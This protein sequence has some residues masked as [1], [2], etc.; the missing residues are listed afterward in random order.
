MRS[1]GRMVDS[2]SFGCFL[3]VVGFIRGRFGVVAFI[4]VRLV[5]VGFIRGRWVH[6]GALSFGVIRV[7][8]WGRS[9]HL[10]APLVHLGSLGSFG[11]VLGIIGFIRG[12]SSAPWWSL[13]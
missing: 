6:S 13:G 11:C 10:V 12:H 3:G 2:G 4:M 9:V 5:V 8:P 7:L 1:G